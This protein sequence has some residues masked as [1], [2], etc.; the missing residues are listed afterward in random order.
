LLF[1]TG[2]GN[3][4]LGGASGESITTGSNNVV[5]GPYSGNSGGLDIR[6]SSNNIVLSDGDGNV[7]VHV[8]SNGKTFIGPENTTDATFHVHSLSNYWTAI[9]YNLSNADVTN[10]LCRHHWATGSNNATQ[11]SF[12]QSNGNEVG[13]I[14]SNGSSTSY[15]TSSDYR[16]K[17]NVDYTW[18]ATT[19]LKQLK[20]ARFNFIADADTTVDGFLAHEAQAVVPESVHGTKD[21]VDADGNAVIPRHRSV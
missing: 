14:K 12:R 19:R 8:D 11:I 2:T 15:N 18:D 21:A 13:S 4:F 1:T 6:T 20:P 10:V 7:R 5:I 16:L 17:E 3:T 9:L